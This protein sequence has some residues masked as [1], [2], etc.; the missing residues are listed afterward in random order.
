M[1]DLLYRTYEYA[2]E[3]GDTE[4]ME[5]Y[6]MSQTMAAAPIELWINDTG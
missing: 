4:L 1:M 6:L 5:H 3:A 2:Y